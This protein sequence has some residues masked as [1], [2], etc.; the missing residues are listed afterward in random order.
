MLF[1]P[2][3]GMIHNLKDNRWH[4]VIFV[5]APLPGPPASDKP[6]RH[7]SKSHHTA[8]FAT[9][10]EAVESVKNDLAPKLKPQAVGEIR[11][12]LDSDFQWDG[13]GI[14]ALTAFFVEDAEGKIFAAF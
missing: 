14:P 3:V 10:K 11:L 6:V 1:N 7:R 12:A 4:P 13:E 8:G 9:R 2:I 5:E